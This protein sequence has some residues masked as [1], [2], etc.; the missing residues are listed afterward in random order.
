MEISAGADSTRA[1]RSSKRRRDKRE[2]SGGNRFGPLLFPLVSVISFRRREN[3][4]LLVTVSFCLKMGFNSV[5]GW[6]QGGNQKENRCRISTS[7]YMQQISV[8]ASSTIDLFLFLRNKTHLFLCSI[9]APSWYLVLLF[10]FLPLVYFPLQSP[11]VT[12]FYCL[13]VIT[14]S[15]FMKC[16][17]ICSV[18]KVT[19]MW[20]TFSEIT[21]LFPFLTITFCQDDALFDLPLVVVWWF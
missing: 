10:L 20:I 11:L 9:L 15:W 2:K 3:N 6:E 1:G 21:W 18:T 5:D 16:W 13:H 8:W 17:K 19:N 7:I 14:A 4:F 12:Y